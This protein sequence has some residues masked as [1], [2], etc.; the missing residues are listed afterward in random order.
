[1]GSRIDV[2]HI[3]LHPVVEAAGLLVV[4]SVL[5]VLTARRRT[6]LVLMIAIAVGGAF[7]FEPI[8]KDF[9]QRPPINPDAGGYS[10]PSGSA[11]RSMAAAAAL[12]VVMWPTRWRW[13][14]TLL[15]AFVVGLIGIAIVSEGWHWASDVIGGWCI[16]VAWVAALSLAFRYVAPVGRRE[17]RSGHRAAASD[18][19]VD[20]IEDVVRE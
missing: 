16:S 12:T 15:C 18:D 1:M 2:L 5:L 17:S 20:G 6:A 8:L 10:F 13:P 3:I 14:T 19:A 9:F 7:I 11:M 4:V